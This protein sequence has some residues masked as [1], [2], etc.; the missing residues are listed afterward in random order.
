MATVKL[1]LSNEGIKSAIAQCREIKKSL[2]KAEKEI[3]ERLATIGA[4]KA[5]LG[6]ASA[7]IQTD[8]DVKVSVRIKGSH[9]TITAAGSEVG[10]IE[11]GSGARYGYGYPVSETEVTAPIGPGTYPLGKGHWDDPKGW[12]YRD[13]AGARHHSYGNPPNA[14]MFYASLAVQEEAERVVREVLSKL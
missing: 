5:T 12:W 1:S 7:V 3:V 4:T 10:F 9:A 11:F 14:P 6:F 13:S 8:N 2:Q